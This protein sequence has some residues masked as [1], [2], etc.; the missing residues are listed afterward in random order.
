M[1]R[2]PFCDDAFHSDQA[3]IDCDTLTDLPVA[4]LPGAPTGLGVEI[5]EGAGETKERGRCVSRAGTER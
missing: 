5:T 1:I 2:D 3:G 4:G